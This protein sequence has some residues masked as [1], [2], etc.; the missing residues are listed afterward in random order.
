MISLRK[1]TPSHQ[2]KRQ[3]RAVAWTTFNL[4][5]GIVRGKTPIVEYF[6][7]RLHAWPGKLRDSPHSCR[8]HR[9][10]DMMHLQRRA[11]RGTK[12]KLKFSL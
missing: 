7:S 3:E 11:K 1:F 5:I 12:W 9:P 8:V 2:L 6:D 10:K 4:R